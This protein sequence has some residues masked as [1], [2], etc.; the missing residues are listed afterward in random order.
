MNEKDLKITERFAFRLREKV[1]D[2]DVI[3]YGSRA[4]GDSS[5]FSDMDVCVT[6]GR[7][8]KRMRDII[9]D[10]AWEVGFS[11]GVVIVP[12]IFEKKEW[13]DSPITE[14]TIYKTIKKE[15]IRL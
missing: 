10:I 5:R 7:L 15:G 11:E 14:S 2:V 3:L 9:F 12:L 6:V 1:D 8:N 13:L 4:R